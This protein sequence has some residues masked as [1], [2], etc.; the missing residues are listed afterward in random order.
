MVGIDGS[1]TSMRA[2][3]YALGLARRQCCR[4]V[5]AFVASPSSLVAA[6]ALGCLTAAEA[7]A[8]HELGA[9]L[10]AHIRAA[11][12]EYQL[13]V[14]FIRCW[15]D[16]YTELRDTADEVKADTLVVGASAG[17]GHR[18]IGSI[19]TRLVRQGHWPVVVVP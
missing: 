19:A 18:L 8:Q 16:P 5:A 2:A 11:A 14:T 13:P 6:T 10:R 1:D 17:T 4:L 7:D 9:D 15:G 12:E 3:A